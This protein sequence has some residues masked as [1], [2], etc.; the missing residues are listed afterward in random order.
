MINLEHAI[1]EEAQRVK[2]MVCSKVASTDVDDVMQDIRLSFFVSF[3]R[4][5]E[6]SK[7]STYAHGIAKR[8][9]AGYFRKRYRAL[10]QYKGLK[11]ELLRRGTE[12]GPQI[13][14]P[15]RG[16]CTLSKS[17]KKVLI[18]VGEGM[19]NAEIAETLYI[20]VN[21]VRSHMKAIYK[22]LPQY[23]NRVR[24]ALFSYRFFKE[25]TDEN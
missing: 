24:L 14:P 17:E 22:K 25:K 7:L 12:T 11:A 20:T 16:Y 19:N 21:T 4:F 6:E 13:S 23:R 5:R 8:Q 9:V 15:K 2:P 18:L 3:P 1:E 10:E